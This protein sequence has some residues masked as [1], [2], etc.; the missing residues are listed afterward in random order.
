M[1]APTGTPETDR[2]ANNP[3]SSVPGKLDEL[4]ELCKKMER[5]LGKYS[6]KTARKLERERDEAR[7]ELEEA[8]R[9]VRVLLR[10]ADRT[11]EKHPAA[12]TQMGQNARVKGGLWLA[13]YDNKREA[14]G[15]KGAGRE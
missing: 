14:L 2:I 11:S 4:T 7:A 1:T 15:E 8:S 9:A 3:N 10:Y 13:R 12:V 6:R 5:N